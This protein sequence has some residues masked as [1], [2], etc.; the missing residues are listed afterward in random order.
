MSE[1]VQTLSPTQQPSGNISLGSSLS[2]SEYNNSRYGFKIQYPSNWQL[3]SIT[4]SSVLPSISD[5]TTEI[6]ARFKSPF[7]PQERMEDLVT[8]SVENLSATSS[9]RG[10]RNLSAYDYAA[11]LIQQLS[12]ISKAPNEPNQAILIIN[13]SLKI[14]SEIGGKDNKNFSA[15]RIDYLSSDYKSDVFVISDTNLFDINFSTSKERATQSVPVF[16]KLL[17]TIQFTN[18][19]S[20]TTSD[21]TFGNTHTINATTDQSIPNL[22][23][24]PSSQILQQGVQPLSNFLQQDQNQNP[25][26]QALLVPPFSTNP[27]DSQLQQSDQMLQ[28]EQQSIPQ[29][30]FGEIEPP[31]QQQPGELFQQLP[32]A[33]PQQTY[34]LLPPS[35]PYSQFPSIPPMSSEQATNYL[36]PVIM[37]QYPY[38]NNLSGLQIVGEVLNQAPVVAKS[39]RVLATSYNQYGQVIGTD[40]A[41]TDPSDL[42]PGQWAPF[43][44][45]LQEGSAPTYQMTNYALNIDWRS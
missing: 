27:S 18:E 42:S 25:Q 35:A 9:Q 3:V 2:F 20:N 28:Q 8:I 15:W 5:N 1:P 11:P 10:I 40:F 31:Y 21:D 45:T 39:V 38:A 13:E 23:I 36:S 26:Q 17:D 44:I 19:K 16:D 30:P 22:R 37:S 32:S 43:N 7:D 14:M 6:I 4:N 29:P 12:P 24:I 33:L 41:Y 34:P